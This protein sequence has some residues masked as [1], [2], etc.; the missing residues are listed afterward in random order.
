MK[1]DLV[2]I[3]LVLILVSGCSSVAKNLGREVDD[4]GRAVSKVEPPPNIVPKVNSVAVSKASTGISDFIKQ[5]G[6]TKGLPYIEKQVRSR[7]PVS[8]QTLADV[9]FS[10]VVSELQKTAQRY[11]ISEVKSLAI[12]EATALINEYNSQNNNSAQVTQ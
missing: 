6:K 9:I 10:E 7:R 4:I 2:S 5:A 3:F 12:S 8:R 11:V 1:K